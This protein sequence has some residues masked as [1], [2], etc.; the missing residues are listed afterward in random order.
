MPRPKGLPK[1]GGR[2]PG[3]LNHAT[4]ELRGF[5]RSV[6]HEALVEN[7]ASRAALIDGIRT[8]S[9]PPPILKLLFE[10][11]YG[12]PARQVD[13]THQGQI[14]LAQLVS[15]SALAVVDDDDVDDVDDDD[16]PLAKV[17]GSGSS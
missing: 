5:L 12:A 7:P 13:V 15:G 14:T 2:Q 1:T 8:L 9:L 3:G 6:F 17:N 11:A 16:L 10:Y 4:K